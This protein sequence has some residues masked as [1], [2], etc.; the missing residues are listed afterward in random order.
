MK[1]LCRLEFCQQAVDLVTL[2][3]HQRLHVLQLA[4][5]LFLEV[6]EMFLHYP[7][8]VCVEPAL[9]QGGHL[10]VT[11]YCTESTAGHQ[12]VSITA[13]LGQHLC[14]SGLAFKLSHR[15]GKMATETDYQAGVLSAAVLHNGQRSSDELTLLDDQRTVG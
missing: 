1:G 4:C 14:V 12:A 10:Q 3:V 5:V 2:P 7:C 13:V 11:A 8:L 15:V 6:N 9:L